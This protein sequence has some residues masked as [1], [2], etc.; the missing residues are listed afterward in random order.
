[1]LP[2]GRRPTWR[3]GVSGQDM[4]GK[5]HRREDRKAQKAASHPRRRYLQGTVQRQANLL[6][7]RH[8][9]V[10]RDLAG[11]GSASHRR[12]LRRGK[13]LGWSL[14]LSREKAYR[15]RL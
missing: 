4:R 11:S 9:F 1:M 10:A 13:W 5:F 14:G 6:P 2:N 8:L 7:L 3:Q 12:T 15:S